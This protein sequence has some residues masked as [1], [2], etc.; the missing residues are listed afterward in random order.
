MSSVVNRFG[1]FGEVAGE[2]SAG[3]FHIEDIQSRSRLYQWQITPHVHLRMF[4]IVW[5][6][7][8][9]VAVK[10]DGAEEHMEGPCAVCVPGSFVHSFIF[11]HQTSGHVVTVSENFLRQGSQ[12]NG[13]ALLET[14]L[15]GPQLIGFDAGAMAQTRI[16][17]L[18][19]HMMQDF[20]ATESERDFL[21]ALALQSIMLLL[22]RQAT[23]GNS[24]A[25]KSGFRR[26]IFLRFER[27]IEK[28]YRAQWTMQR[29]CDALAISQARLYRIC[30]EFSGKTAIALVQERVALEAR[31]H[32][33]Y[34]SAPVEMI[35]Y[36]LGFRDPA[37]FNRCFK[38]WTGYTPGAFRNEQERRQVS[39]KSV[40][41]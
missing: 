10:L 13:M 36:D 7:K 5:V 12:Q 34:T 30:R 31:R 37:Y 38:R 28:H 16:C 2:E 15:Q 40:R 22:Q 11:D 1:L 25:G 21:F 6:A 32:L 26:D 27:L 29:Y 3:F 23:T 35:A 33:V 19:D 39:T 4:Q 9:P 41:A 20:Y 17:A 14:F 8:G 18:L 24:S